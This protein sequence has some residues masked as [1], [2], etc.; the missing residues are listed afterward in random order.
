MTTA[1]CSCRNTIA[2]PVRELALARSTSTASTVPFCTQL[3]Y[4][5]HGDE[6]ALTYRGG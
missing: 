5:E 2:R 3:T 1:R 4:L 6:L